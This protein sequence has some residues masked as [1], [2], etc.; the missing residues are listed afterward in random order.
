MPFSFLTNDALRQ[1][2]AGESEMRKAALDQEKTVGELLKEAY[3][4]EEEEEGP[5]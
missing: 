3:A 5:I 2:G 4:E 1:L